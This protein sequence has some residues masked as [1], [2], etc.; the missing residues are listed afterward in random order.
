MGD[1]GRLART[2]APHIVHAVEASSFL[3]K[4]Q[5]LHRQRLRE[6]GEEEAIV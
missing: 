3:A 5:V 4:V 2:A 1:A 6:E